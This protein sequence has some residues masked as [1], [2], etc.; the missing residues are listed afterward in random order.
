MILST[1]CC[2]A[3]FTV[4]H[5]A[6]HGAIS[7]KYQR[8]NTIIGSIA[9]L[10]LGPTSSWQAIKYNHLT[11]HAH[12]NH[13]EFDPDYWC[14][15]NGPGGYY[16]TPLRWFTVD[17]SY[18]LTFI[19][20]FLNDST[21]DKLMYLGYEALMI[22]FLY[23]SIQY[24]FF[25]TLLQFWIIPARLATAF[26]AFAFDFLP[27]YPHDVLR[28]DNK[29]KTTTYLSAGTLVRPFLSISIFY[30][31][32]HV[33]HHLVPFVPFYRYKEVFYEMSH[34]LL[35][36][37]EIEVRRILPALGVETLPYDNENRKEKEE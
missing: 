32:Y 2:Y 26:L 25:L 34:E 19:P 15:L 16:L 5:D 10:W 30:Q 9:Q 27:H 18:L 24:G 1:I 11:H 6:I 23:I 14:S 29:W 35:N 28:K 4:A 36:E 21:T 33:A 8:L 7:S 17:V 13:P 20:K 12:T 22:A 37:R 3:Q 31:N